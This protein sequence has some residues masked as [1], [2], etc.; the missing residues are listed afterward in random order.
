MSN[1]EV[2]VFCVVQV[3]DPKWNKQ[4]KEEHLEEYKKI[5]KLRPKARQHNNK[6]APSLYESIP[7]ADQE[8]EGWNKTDKTNMKHGLYKKKYIDVKKPMVRCTGESPPAREFCAPRSSC[9]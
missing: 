6:I 8:I 9:L 3:H 4:K 7:L 5:F 1:I 2:S